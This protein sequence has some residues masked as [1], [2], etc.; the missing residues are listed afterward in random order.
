MTSKTTKGRRSPDWISKEVALMYDVTPRYV[1]QIRNGKGKGH[2][3][4]KFIMDSVMDLIEAK[5]RIVVEVK[6]LIPFDKEAK[7]NPKKLGQLK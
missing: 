5:T 2:G 4:D 6:K 3:K 1:N 7:R